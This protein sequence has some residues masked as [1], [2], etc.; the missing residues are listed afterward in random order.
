MYTNTALV[1]LKVEIHGKRVRRVQIPIAAVLWVPSEDVLWEV[2]Y[3]KVVAL[4]EVCFMS[5][6]I[7][8]KFLHQTLRSIE[9][10][11]SC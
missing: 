9:G 1:H 5:I 4:V 8:Q 2:I 6:R 10:L 7:N 3:C 11:K